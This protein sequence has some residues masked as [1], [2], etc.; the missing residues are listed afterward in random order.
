VFTT[1]ISGCLLPPEQLLSIRMGRLIAMIVLILFVAVAM[2]I[3]VRVFLRRIRDIQRAQ[4][5]D[6][7]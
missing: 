1:S 2:G 5:G 3:V 4:W 6:D 7:A